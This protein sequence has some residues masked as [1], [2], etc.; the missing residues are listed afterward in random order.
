MFIFL[1]IYAHAST[2]RR[3]REKECAQ[4][5][6]IDFTNENALFICCFFLFIT[7]NFIFSLFICFFFCFQKIEKEKRIPAIRLICS[8]LKHYWVQKLK[9]IDSHFIY[10]AY[11]SKCEC[12]SR[13]MRSERDLIST[14]RKAKRNREL[15]NERKQRM[16][17]NMWMKVSVNGCALD[18]SAVSINKG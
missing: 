2:P 5:W 6:N 3:Q 13:I 8:M 17:A 7:S 1:Q 16:I 4:E 11:I 12:S 15:K 18:L 14:S 10:A 9:I